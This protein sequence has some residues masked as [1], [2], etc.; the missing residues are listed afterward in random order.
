[1][2]QDELEHLCRR[3][4]LRCKDL[5]VSKSNINDFEVEFICDYKKTK[6]S[7]RPTAAP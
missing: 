7:I 6:V 1:M 4:K 5:D 3:E 2:L